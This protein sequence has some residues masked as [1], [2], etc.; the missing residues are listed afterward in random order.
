M[1]L[2]QS[3]FYTLRENVKDEETISGNL[4]VKSGMI[5][6]TS[7]GI[8]MYTPLGYRVLNNVNRIIREE[9]NKAGAEEMLMPSMLSSEVFERSGRKE[10]FGSDMFTFFDRAGR[11]CVLGPTHEE[12]F[13]DIAKMKIKSYKDMPFTIYQTADKFRDE[14]RPRFGLIRVREFIMKDAYSFDTSYEEL[15]NSYNKMFE[16][17]KKT[18]DRMN[19]DY[20]IVRADTGVMG[21]LLS[22]EF[23]AVTNIG[24]DILVLCDEC[25]FASNIEVSKCIKQEHT[26]ED[27]KEIEKIFTPNAK[28]IE[29]VSEFLNEDSTKF[30][31]TLIYK[32]DNEFYAICVPGDREV[33]ETKV[34]KL[35]KAQSIE[36]AEAEDVVRITNANV[37]FAGPVG[38]QGVKIIIDENV[39]ETCNFIV[40]ANETNYHLK[41]VNIKDFKYDFSGDIVNVKDGDKC[42]NCGK[43]LTFK[44]G[45]EIGNTFKLGDKYSKL[46]D[47]S[48]LDKEG[49]KQYVIMGCYGMGPGRIIAS[50]IEQN[51]DEKGIKF[52]ISVAPYKVAI[53]LINNKDESQ[54]K[55]AN[56][57]HDLL[58]ENN[59]DTILDDRQDRPGVKFNDMDLIGIPIRITVGKKIAENKVE[60]KLRNE[61][62]S[63]DIDIT[64]YGTILETIKNIIEK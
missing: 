48:Y 20:R 6:K 55:I 31:K 30:V 13:V 42:P 18:F 39:L 35:L 57:L 3:F 50:I 34:L 8:Y 46:L 16:A 41:N 32:I 59:I 1:R 19:I 29:E 14:P 12:M 40:G 15:D 43:P 63:N 44:R 26:K 25:G 61:E 37:G 10:N 64:N 27:Y 60:L 11:E 58:E 9:M 36:L 24:E 51:N 33:N 53:V 22:E 2:S 56:E 38:L 28:T 52:P 7:S 47:L 5:R 45:I 49:K 17:Y 62:T 23:Q 4:L 54:V 21:G